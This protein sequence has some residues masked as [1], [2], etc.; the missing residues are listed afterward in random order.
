MALLSWGEQ[1]GLID[2]GMVREDDFGPVVTHRR[3]QQRVP[4]L[5]RAL[6]DAAKAGAVL[7]AQPSRLTA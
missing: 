3:R 6:K 2:A 7:S 5:T 4:N 1:Q